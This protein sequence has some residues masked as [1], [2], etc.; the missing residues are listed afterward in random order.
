MALNSKIILDGLILLIAG[1]GI[2]S[3][4]RGIWNLQD[5]FLPKRPVLSNAVSLVVGL[6]IVAAMYSFFPEVFGE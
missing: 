6:L 2:I 1:I 4:W 5:M 3:F